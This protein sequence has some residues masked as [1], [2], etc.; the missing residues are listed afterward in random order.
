MDR[1]TR[2]PGAADGTAGTALVTGASSGM[3]AATARRLAARGHDLVLVARREDRLKALAGEVSAE[4]GVAALAVPLDLE[5]TDELSDAL[6]GVLAALPGPLTA[7]VLAA[8][9]GRGHGPVREADPGPWESQLRVNLLAP[10]LLVRALLP[11]LDAAGGDLVVIGSLFGTRPSP[12][13]A[14]YAATK[15]GLAGFVRSL[16]EEERPA[17][18]CRICLI[19]PGATNTE[20]ASVL[21]GARDPRVHDV[22]DWP[23][24]PLLAEDVAAGVEWVLS[25][26]AHA[27]VTELTVDPLDARY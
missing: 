26:P 14:P 18:G 17:P 1:S 12:G 4:H 20:F 25:R 24:H 3:G 5:R 22:A 27:R 23:Y 10:M 8:G 6:T 13:Y 15:Y 19:S 21:A 2:M 7:A 9:H 11:A 16:A